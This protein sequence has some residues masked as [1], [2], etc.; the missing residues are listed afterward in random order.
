[1]TFSA[2]MAGLDGGLGVFLV[3]VFAI[4]RAV[5]RRA[6]RLLQPSPTAR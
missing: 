2:T 1:V 6:R 3:L 4:E 5:R